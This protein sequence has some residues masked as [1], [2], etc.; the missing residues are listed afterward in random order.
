MKH[1]IKVTA[2]IIT[3]FLIAQLIGLFVVSKYS[4]EVKQGELVNGT[5]TNFTSYNLPYG[6]D[7]PENNPGVNLI[8]I[9]IAI[10]IAVFIM[11]LLMKT[12]MPI[13]ITIDIR[14]TPGLFSGGSYP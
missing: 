2:L 4:P 13:A 7:P 1:N 5:A 9:V 3:L 6:Y 14:L 10:G 11:F 8:S 12:A